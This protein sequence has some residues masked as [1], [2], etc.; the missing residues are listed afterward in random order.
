LPKFWLKVPRVL[1][2][3]RGVIRITWGVIDKAGFNQLLVP[4]QSQLS[5]LPFHST[6]SMPAIRSSFIVPFNPLGNL[7]GT[8]VTAAQWYN[9][10]FKRIKRGST[11]SPYPD[12]ASIYWRSALS[13]PKD[14][15]F[16]DIYLN[17]IFVVE[18]LH[19]LG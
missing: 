5:S 9:H 15:M 10:N 13:D 1:C 17:D 18:L 8:L 12:P 14:N 7:G 11:V 3:L 2:R 19:P 16:E 6:L 4:H